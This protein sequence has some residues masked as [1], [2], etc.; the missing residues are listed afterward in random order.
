MFG[1]EK[2]VNNAASKAVI[3]DGSAWWGGGGCL[4]V[5]R[6]RCRHGD[7]DEQRSKGLGKI[8]CG[9]MHMKLGF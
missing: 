1:A 8:F 5:G 7:V 3:S 9:V 2:D 6:C 4:P